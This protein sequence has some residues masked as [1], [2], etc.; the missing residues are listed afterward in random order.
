MLDQSI[1]ISIRE[2]LVMN[3]LKNSNHHSYLSNADLK[4]GKHTEKAFYFLDE[5]YSYSQQQGLE[6]GLKIQE[7]SKT[8]LPPSKINI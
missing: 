4:Y 5:N 3:G 7:I 8:S 6:T 2:Q 1:T